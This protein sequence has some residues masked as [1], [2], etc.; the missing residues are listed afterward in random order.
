LVSLVVLLSSNEVIKMKFLNIK[1]KDR[2]YE[3]DILVREHLN[4]MY[5]LA[6]RMTRNPIDAED[7][8]Q[9]TALKAYRFFHKFETGTNFKAW[10]YRIL[11]NNYINIYRKSKKAPSRVDIDKVDFKLEEKGAGYWEKLNDRT[12]DYA[13]EDLFDD[14]INAAM[15]TLPD[16]YKLVVLLSDVESLSYK[17]IAKIIDVPIGTVMSRLHRGRKMLQKRLSKYAKENGYVF[18]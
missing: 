2:K 1:P 5:T 17:E 4:G 11:T 6:V 16:E 7:L 15:D 8:V 3:F 9:E 10:I 12:N 18:Y 13:Y 14:E